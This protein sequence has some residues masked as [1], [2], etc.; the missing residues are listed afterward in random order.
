MNFYLPDFCNKNFK[1][2]KKIIQLM[3]QHPEYF[4]DN[5]QIYDRHI[6]EVKEMLKREPIDCNPKI[7]LNEDKTNFYD[8]TVDSFKLEN[9]NW[10][11]NIRNIPVA[12]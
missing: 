6:N 4:Y 3:N 2:N 7:I 9:Y 12:V 5:I 8:F 11:N 1:L 10:V